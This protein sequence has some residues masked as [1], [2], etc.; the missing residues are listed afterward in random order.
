MRCIEAGTTRQGAGSM[1]SGIESPA[2]QGGNRRAWEHHR[3]A[4]WHTVDHGCSL[5]PHRTHCTCEPP[6][7]AT[8]MFSRSASSPTVAASR[9]VSGEVSAAFV[10][11][12]AA[13]PVASNAKHNPPGEAGVSQESW[14]AP[15][16]EHLRG[17]GRRKA[18]VS[19]AVERAARRPVCAARRHASSRGVSSGCAVGRS[20]RTRV[21]RGVAFGRGPGA[22]GP[23]ARS[24]GAPPAR[25]PHWRHTLA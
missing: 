4:A 20:A 9:A 1:P 21:G 6:L 16:A 3:G 22:H 18:C 10:T 23:G 15:L 7:P 14:R 2:H 12:I 25:K 13:G 11:W 19:T 17:A 8:H 5:T 24:L